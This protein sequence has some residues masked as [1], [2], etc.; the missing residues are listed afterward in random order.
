MKVV[1]D[2]MALPLNGEIPET[3]LVVEDDAAIFRL[4][5]VL[6]ASSAKKSNTRRSP[7]LTNQSICYFRYH[8]AGHVRA[9]T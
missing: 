2:S 8:D 9:R 1:I 7:F 6:A 3:L 5:E 4:V